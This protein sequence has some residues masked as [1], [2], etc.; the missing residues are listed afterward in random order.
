ME[1][2]FGSG[3]VR[4]QLFSFHVQGLDLK[5]KFLVL[6]YKKTENLSM[7]SKQ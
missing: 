3:C 4:L 7:T 6:W 1:T 2:I 5:T